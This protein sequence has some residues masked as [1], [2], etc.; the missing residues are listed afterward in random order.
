MART[1]RRGRSTGARWRKPLHGQLHSTPWSASGMSVMSA[2]PQSR[3]DCC[4]G[5]RPRRRR[6][7][8]RRAAWS[9]VDDLHDAGID[10]LSHRLLL[11]C[12]VALSSGRHAFPQLRRPARPPGDN[13]TCSPRPPDLPE[14]AH[15]LCLGRRGFGQVLGSRQDP[16]WQT[17]Q[18]PFPPQTVGQQAAATAAAITVWPG[19]ASKVI[20]DGATVTVGTSA[21]PEFTPRLAASRIDLPFQAQHPLTDDVALHF[22]RSTGDGE[23]TAVQGAHGSP[24][25]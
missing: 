2:P 20:P 12:L 16:T 24:A 3:H 19:A 10:E 23:S 8:G 11:F 1:R 22:R 4:V 13:R 25:A 15:R 7:S 5:I 9:T 14:V 21:A 18:S 6:R 17:R